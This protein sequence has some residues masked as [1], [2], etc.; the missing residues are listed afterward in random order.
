MAL[1][2]RRSPYLLHQSL[3][4]PEFPGEWSARYKWEALMESLSEFTDEARRGQ[5][6]SE[7]R[8]QMNK[9]PGPFTDRPFISN[10]YFYLANDKLLLKTAT[11]LPQFSMT[12]FCL[13]YIKFQKQARHLG[14]HFLLIKNTMIRYS[15]KNNNKNWCPCRA[16]TWRHGENM[17]SV[18]QNNCHFPCE[19]QTTR[20][21]INVDRGNRGWL[22]GL[23]QIQHRSHIQS[24]GRLFIGFI[25]PLV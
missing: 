4:L 9:S 13:K 25:T 11:C 21:V 23:I 1:W 18:Q 2:K 15:N 7:V 8:T 5:V 16:E 22:V 3:L 6:T 24:A 10:H 20:T 14:A 17:E 19:S 12:C